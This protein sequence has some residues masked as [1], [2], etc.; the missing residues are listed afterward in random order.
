MGGF[1]P[2]AGFFALVGFFEPGGVRGA[3]GFVVPS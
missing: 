1:F 2:T 3:V